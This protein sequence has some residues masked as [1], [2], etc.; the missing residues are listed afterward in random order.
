MVLP[1]IIIFLL[2]LTLHPHVFG[3]FMNI[4]LLR[5]STF[6]KNSIESG[7]N[8]FFFYY[9]AFSLPFRLLFQSFCSSCLNLSRSSEF[10]SILNIFPTV[11]N[12]LSFYH[13]MSYPLKCRQFTPILKDMKTWSFQWIKNS[14]Q[15]LYLFN[16]HNLSH[17][18][19]IFFK[20]IIIKP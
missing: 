14:W 19:N 9:S 12:W 4:F 3:I 2:F 10:F 8:F 17:N 16:W 1:L 5:R 20:N 15:F 7:T 11:Y 13:F 18:H 6:R